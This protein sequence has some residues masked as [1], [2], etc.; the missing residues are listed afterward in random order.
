MQASRNHADRPLL[1]PPQYNPLT[2]PQR[3]P[4]RNV[5]RGTRA[6]PARQTSYSKDDALGSQLWELSEALLRER[7]RE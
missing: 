5:Y 1:N 7:V 2:P 4:L 6:V 3:T